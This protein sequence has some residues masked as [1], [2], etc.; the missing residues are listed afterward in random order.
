MGE[1]DCK[2]VS[3]CGSPQASGGKNHVRG[4]VEQRLVVI[5]L[6]IGVDHDRNAAS[7]RSTADRQHKTW[8]AIINQNGIHGGHQPVRI[9]HSRVV[10]TMIPIVHNGAIAVSIDENR[11]H[12]CA[13]LRDAHAVAALHAFALQPLNEAVPNRINTER[14]RKIRL[15]A[16]SGYRDRGI[17]RVAAPDGDELARLHLG[18]RHRKRADAKNFVE[19]RDAGAENFRHVRT[20]CGR[21]RARRG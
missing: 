20:G 12:R 9:V 2:I 19:N 1:T 17:G 11:R 18:I 13:R 15:A 14:R 16:E 7:H 10:K 8:E 5:R 6:L 3:S 4:G 21:L